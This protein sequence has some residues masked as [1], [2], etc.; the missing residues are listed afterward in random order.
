MAKVEKRASQ[1]AKEGKI[2]RTVVRS[3]GLRLRR[4]RQERELT[5]EAAA[6]KSALDWKHWQKI[7]SGSLNFTLVTLT[8]I[9][10]GLKV[11]LKDLFVDVE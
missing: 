7:E 3:F 9:A 4:L 6:E 1:T 8:R 2:Y 5:L 10:K 11:S